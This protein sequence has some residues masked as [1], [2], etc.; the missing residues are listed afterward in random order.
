S[1][2][3]CVAVAVAVLGF[4]DCCVPILD[5]VVEGYSSI[6]IVELLAV[7]EAAKD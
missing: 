5:L 4:L 2:D 3:K 1:L 7:A 6:R